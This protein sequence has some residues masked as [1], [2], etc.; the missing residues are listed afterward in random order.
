LSNLYFLDLDSN[1][2]SGTI[3]TELLSLSN[4]NYLDLHDNVLSGPVGG[5]GGAFPQLLLAQLH[6]NLFTGTIPESMAV[7]SGLG[8]SFGLYASR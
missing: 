8:T 3:S 7:S 6:N 2:I 5:I 1:Q 4:L